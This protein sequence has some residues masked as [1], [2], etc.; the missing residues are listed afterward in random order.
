MTTRMDAIKGRDIDMLTRREFICLC[1][2]ACVVS[3]YRDAI[4]ALALPVS[5]KTSLAQEY[6][7]AT[8]YAVSPDGKMICLEDWGERRYPLRVVE[9]GSWRTIFK[10]RFRNRIT[11]ASF[12][13]N[14]SALFV[15]GPGDRFEKAFWWDILNLADGQHLEHKQPQDVVMVGGTE[16]IAALSASRL[17]VF[18]YTSRPYLTQTVELIELPDYRELAKVPY[19]TEPREPRRR[20]LN[21]E[22][23]KDFGFG[24]SDDR[25]TLAYSFDHTL[26]SRRT[27]DLQLL[28]ERKTGFATYAQKVAVSAHG[29]RIAAAFSDNSISHLQK[30]YCVVVYDGKDGKEVAKLP[31]TGTDGIAISPDGKL[32]ATVEL[33]YGKGYASP[34]VHIH[35]VSTG[36]EVAKLTHDVIKSRRH[37]WLESE[38]GCRVRFTSDGKYLITS[39]MTTKVWKLGE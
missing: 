37:Q 14:N 18:R 27:K 36:N 5:L 17:L 33:V 9:I 8:E 10:G 16:Q 11:F 6:A 12:F 24:V 28:W 32:V 34:T 15:R 26:L 2:S 23:S 35:E 3:R 31:I 20:E 25:S 22:L 21:I 4:V 13:S 39:G 29:D 38:A 7:K 30:E 1:A 19:A